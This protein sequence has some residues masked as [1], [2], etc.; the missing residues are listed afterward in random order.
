MSLNLSLYVLQSSAF[1]LP[2]VHS[3]ILNMSTVV[4][5]FY[6]LK[7]PTLQMLANMDHRLYFLPFLPPGAGASVSLRGALKTTGPDIKGADV[8]TGAGSFLVRMSIGRKE[9]LLSSGFHQ[10]PTPGFRY[11]RES[12]SNSLRTTEQART[13]VAPTRHVSSCTSCFQ[14]Y[15]GMNQCRILCTISTSSKGF[16]SVVGDRI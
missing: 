9:V 11:R 4:C 14:L 2:L 7:T 8:V 6:T 12:A 10:S 16:F 15:M 5:T 1:I 13:C 3:D